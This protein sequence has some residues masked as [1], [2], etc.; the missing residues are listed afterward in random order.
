LG[1]LVARRDEFGNHSSNEADND[2]PENAKH[3]LPR[4]YVVN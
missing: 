4:D 1:S 3:V 2:G